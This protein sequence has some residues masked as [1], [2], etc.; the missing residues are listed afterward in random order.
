MNQAIAS[1]S[2]QADRIAR[3]RKLME[4]RHARIPTSECG[5]YERGCKECKEEMDYAARHDERRPRQGDQYVG[6]TLEQIE[7]T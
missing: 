7:E 6:L 3:A 4:E 5:C 2:T 1:F